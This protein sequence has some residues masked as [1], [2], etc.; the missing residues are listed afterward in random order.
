MPILSN[1]RPGTLFAN[2]DVADVSVVPGMCY[3]QIDVVGTSGTINVIVNWGAGA[4]TIKTIDLALTD[5][6]ATILFGDVQTIQLSPSGV[7]G[8]YTAN[9]I[10]K[11][12]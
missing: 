8:N 2:T 6:L 4:K 5:N 11:S 12:V 3:H 9:Y 10:A 7:V 1:D